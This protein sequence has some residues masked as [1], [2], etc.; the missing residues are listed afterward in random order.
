MCA[1]SYAGKF[2]ATTYD[3]QQ[4]AVGFPLFPDKP[5]SQ[6]YGFYISL[7]PLLTNEKQHYCLSF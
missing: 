6:S 5:R 2:L 1:M 7:E 3:G 4:E